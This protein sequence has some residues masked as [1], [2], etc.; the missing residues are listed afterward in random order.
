MR[1]FD[2]ATAAQQTSLARLSSDNFDKFGVNAGIEW[3]AFLVM[4]IMASAAFEA[5]AA[6]E[7]DPF[8]T[9]VGT[10]VESAAIWY[11]HLL[12]GIVQKA[13]GIDQGRVIFEGDRVRVRQVRAD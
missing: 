9:R 10:V 3:S 13:V 7:E 1:L 4:D 2:M 8:D 12:G 11:E 6:I 5:V